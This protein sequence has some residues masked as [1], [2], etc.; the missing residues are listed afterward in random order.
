MKELVFGS[1]IM[2][3]AASG[4]SALSTTNTTDAAALAAATLA[5]SSGITIVGGSQSLIGST[6]QQG[7]YTGFNLTTSGTPGTSN[8]SLGNGV[9]LTTGGGDFGTTNTSSSFSHQPGTGSYAPL[10]NLASTK[11]LS[12]NQNDSNVLSFDFTLDDP[13]Q[14]A[15]K[16]QFI[17]ATDEFADQ[18]VTDILGI[19]VN[20]VNYAF[21]PN[22][23]LV[24]NQSGDPHD[25]FNNNE[26]GLGTYNIEWDGLTAVFDITLLA[27]GGGAVNTFALAI[28]DTWDQVWDSAVFFTG[29]KAANDTGS[30]GITDP[31][32]PLP[33]AGWL[34]VT[35]FGG[36]AAA[37]RR[38]RA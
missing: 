12:T 23:D 14:N 10:V 38:K 16:A 27:N 25:F 36:V 19:F 32:V 7:T 15:V 9:F 4:A 22:G 26:V 13:T 1:L 8:L 31:V 17:F 34:L 28:A 37:A 20:G 11:G 21:F 6:V 33:A 5:A 18:G 2:A 35:A 24:S 30:G 3:C 29:L